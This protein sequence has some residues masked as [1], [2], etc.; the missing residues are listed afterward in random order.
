MQTLAEDGLTPITP[1]LKL[2][3]Q[4]GIDELPQ[5]RN[6]LA[7]DMSLV[8]RRPLIPDEYYRQYEIVGH[9]LAGAKLVDKHKATAGVAKP[10]ILST[11][12][13]QGHRGNESVMTLASRLELDVYDFEHASHQ[14]S[15]KLVKTLVRSLAHAELQHGDIRIKETG[16]VQGE[17]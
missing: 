3:R 8:G 12:A 11:H 2:F 4:S 1:L 13:I 9:D 16:V 6:I 10:G 5:I 7:G 14:H 17:S 15:M